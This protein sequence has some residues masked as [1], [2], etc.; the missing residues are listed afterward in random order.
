MAKPMKIFLVVAAALSLCACNTLI[1]VGRDTKQGFIWT[2]NKIQ[3]AG[4][5]SS[6]DYSGAPVY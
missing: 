4:Q 3:G 1:G 6:D 5:S 2:K